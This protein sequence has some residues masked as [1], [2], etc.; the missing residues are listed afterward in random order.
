MRRMARPAIICLPVPADAAAGGGIM[1]G[2][3]PGITRPMVM[4]MAMALVDAEI[5]RLILECSRLYGCR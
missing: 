1:L 5:T 4:A 3:R 2:L